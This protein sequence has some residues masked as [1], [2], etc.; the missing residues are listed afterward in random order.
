MPHLSVDRRAWVVALSLAGLACHRQASGAQPL[1]EDAASGV[2]AQH[3]EPSPATPESAP[4]DDDRARRAGEVEAMARTITAEVAGRRNLALTGEFAVELIDRA[5]V[6]E[7]VREAL[8]AELTR[9]EIRLFGRIESALG[10]LP[11]GADGEQVLLDLYE[12]GVLGIYDPERKTLLIGD[13]VGT[14]ELGRVIGHEGAHGLQ[15]MHFDLGALAK[16]TKG[17]SD[18][19][20]AKTFLIEGDAEAAYLAW[21]SG[22]SGLASIGD[23]LLAMQADMVLGIDETMIPHA[24]L[25]R[26]LQMP[27]TEGTAA[28]V[29][30]AREQGF[31][32]IDALYADLP[33]SSE[34]LLHPDKL[35]KRE[36]PLAITIDAAPLLA[37][38]ADHREVWQDELGEA[39]LLAMLAEV[40]SPG[41]AREAAAGWGGDRFVVLDRQTEPA[42]APLLVGVI[43]WDS[44]ADAKQFEPALRTYLEYTK[45]DEHL[46]QRRGKQVLYATHFGAALSGQ[47]DPLAALAKAGWASMTLSK[48][49]KSGKSKSKAK[50]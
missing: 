47:A 46:V 44:E 9:E 48:P 37:L 12:I 41:R 29:R 25:T 16:P 27:Y 31:A 35:A 14:T 17:R 22:A 34:Q 20:T 23:D 50:P 43:A 18:F 13:F 38:A 24:T 19:D 1:E 26:K 36:A 5:G 7:F 3:V 11:V 2:E 6:R 49:S 39:G 10:V 42:A 21:L 40:E 4:V 8:Y 32:A 15:D 28:M 45:P 30:L 33:S